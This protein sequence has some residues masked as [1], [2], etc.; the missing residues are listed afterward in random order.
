MLKTRE[1]KIE[2]LE[3]LVSD[4]IINCTTLLPP[5][6]RGRVVGNIVG[7]VEEVAKNIVDIYEPQIT[8]F[9]EEDHKKVLKDLVESNKAAEATGRRKAL[10]EVLTYFREYFIQ[11]SIDYFGN[12]E[13]VITMNEA[14]WDKFE[15]DAIAKFTPDWS[16]ERANAFR[17]KLD[18]GEEAYIEEQEHCSLI[19]RWPKPDGLI[20]GQYYFTNRERTRLVFKSFDPDWPVNYEGKIISYSHD[21]GKTWRDV[22][23]PTV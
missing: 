19:G 8:V 9:T 2:Y 18:N 6:E 7:F 21:Y 3:H 16:I 11:K 23:E 20:G 15:E 13:V 22:N 10:E 14:G 5:Q 12:P 1:E 4:T 17:I